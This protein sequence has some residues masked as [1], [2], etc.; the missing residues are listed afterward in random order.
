MP[1]RRQLGSQLIIDIISKFISLTLKC[2]IREMIIK[3]L[4]LYLVIYHLLME[5]CYIFFTKFIQNVRKCTCTCCSWSRMFSKS[6]TIISTDI[7]LIIPITFISIS[8]P[9]PWKTSTVRMYFSSFTFL[10]FK[11]IYDHKTPSIII[12]KQSRLISVSKLSF[13]S[14]R[15]TT[16]ES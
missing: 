3:Y 12:E 10:S 14:K 13:A 9:A 4:F 1:P 7:K 16:Q 6:V 11:R 8:L 5:F 2:P 15:Y